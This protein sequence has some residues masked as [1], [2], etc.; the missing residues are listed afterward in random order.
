MFTNNSME[1]KEDYVRYEKHSTNDCTTCCRLNINEREFWAFCYEN[2]TMYWNGEAI[3]NISIEK[4][5]EHYNKMSRLPY[6]GGLE[7]NL[8]WFNNVKEWLES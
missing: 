3:K 6:A 8:Q 5:L 2:K 1:L 4:H 7:A